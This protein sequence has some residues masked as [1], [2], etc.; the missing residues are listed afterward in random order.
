MS[1]EKHHCMA[2]FKSDHFGSA[3]LEE[4]IEQGNAPIFK[5]LQ[6]KQEYG[7]KV[8]GKKGDHNVAYFENHKKPWVLNSTNTKQ[9]RKFQN[10]EPFVEDWKPMLVELYVDENVKAVTGGTTQ[11]VRIRPM[12]PVQ[13]Q[14]PKPEFKEINFEPAFKANATIEMITAGYTLTPEM[15]KKYEEYVAEKS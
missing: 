13:T 6:V 14:Q 11:G 4:Y 3:D 15:Q 10:G 12:Q 7:I 2:V 8:A 5:I 1:T 9:L